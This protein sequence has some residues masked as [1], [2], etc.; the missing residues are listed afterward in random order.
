M[1]RK[2]VWITGL[3]GAGKTTAAK[4]VFA[5]IKERSPNTVMLDGDDFREV[6]DGDLGYGVDDRIKNARRIVKM[7]GYLCAQ[8][9][10]VVCATMSLYRE[11]HEFIYE[12]FEDPLV[13]F[14]DVSMNELKKRNKKN[15]YSGGVDVSGVDQAFDEPRHGKYVMKINNTGDLSLTVNKIMERIKYY[16]TEI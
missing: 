14:L 1:R 2:L 5:M 4:Q 16:D 12:N 10:N 9:M 8:D 3:S 6:F 11:I 7:C 15:L 13:V